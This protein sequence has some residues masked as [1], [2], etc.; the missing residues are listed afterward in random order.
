MC[1]QSYINFN[2]SHLIMMRRIRTVIIHNTRNSADRLTVCNFRT[3]KDCRFETTLPP[4]STLRDRDPPPD[5]PSPARSLARYHPRFCHQ[6]KIPLT[7]KRMMTISYYRTHLFFFYIY[8]LHQVLFARR[9]RIPVMYVT[10][11]KSDVNREKKDG[12]LRIS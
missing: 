10:A 8:I 12:Y 7:P 1:A 9:N 4:D 6:S 2:Q 3:F 5:N 11:M